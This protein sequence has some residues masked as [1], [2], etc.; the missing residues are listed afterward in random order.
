M[1]IYELGEK[2]PKTQGLVPMCGNSYVAVTLALN[3]SLLEEGRRGSRC[4]A[5]M[6]HKCVSWIHS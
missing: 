1:C 4:H 3:H 5:F 6:L 2:N